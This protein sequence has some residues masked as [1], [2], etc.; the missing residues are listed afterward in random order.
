MLCPLL[1]R[2]GNGRTGGGTTK[3]RAKVITDLCT[4]VSLTIVF[5]VVVVWCHRLTFV[6][7]SQAQLEAGHRFIKMYSARTGM[8]S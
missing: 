8:H 7:Y 1:S 6:L 5:T 2:L 4:W 3:R